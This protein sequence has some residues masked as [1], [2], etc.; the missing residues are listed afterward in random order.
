LV[1]AKQQFGDYSEVKKQEI[2]L[3]VKEAKIR[4][5]VTAKTAA[6]P[7]LKRVCQ[8]R[9]PSIKKLCNG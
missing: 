7:M 9:Q 2:F 3:T 1:L 6:Q 8:R 5:L 4:G